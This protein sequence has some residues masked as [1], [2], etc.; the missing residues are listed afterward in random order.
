MK[1][2]VVPFAFAALLGVASPVRAAISTPTGTLTV[3]SRPPGAAFEIKGAIEISGRTPVTLTPRVTGRFE[4]RSTEP[5][6]GTWRRVLNFDGVSPDT[7]WMALSRKSQLGAGLRSIAVPGWGQSYSGHPVAGAAFLG[8]AVL[9][10]AGFELTRLRYEDR[11]DGVDG[12]YARLNAST[13]PAQVSAA[14]SALHS[15]ESERDGALRMR[16]I[17]GGTLGGVWAISFLETLAGFPS[18]SDKSV[19]LDLAPASFGAPGPLRAALRVR[20]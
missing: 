15:A 16:R 5:G 2:N 7:V 10:G 20:F 3:L 8:A 18:V 6:Y 11:Q 19:S 14:R 13:T 1:R 9:A 12:A 17:V 4:L